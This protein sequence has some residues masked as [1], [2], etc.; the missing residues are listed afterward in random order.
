MWQSKNL[1]IKINSV[2]LLYLIFNEVNGY[3]DGI[4]GNKYL[5]I[6]STNESKKNQRD[7]KNYGVKSEIQL[8]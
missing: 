1:R 2:N 8:G 4:N 5:T 7:I 6:V 3:F